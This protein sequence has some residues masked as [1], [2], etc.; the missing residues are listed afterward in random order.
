MAH[1]VLSAILS[2]PSL[3]GK[4][5]SSFPVFLKITG[6][7]L[8]VIGEENVPDEPVLFIGN[9]HHHLS[10]F[11]YNASS[12]YRRQHPACSYVLW[13]RPMASWSKRRPFPCD[14]KRT[15]KGPSNHCRRPW[16]YHSGR[17]SFKSLIRP[18][19]S[20][21]K[22]SCKGKIAYAAIEP[23]QVRIKSRCTLLP[24]VFI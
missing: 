4:R 23:R 16:R 11:F 6:V 9:H 13:G 17:P 18:L 21:P 7:E 24:S 20:M 2:A 5:E 10:R 3:K 12:S 14:R 15:W 19:E 22:T 1:P 8:T